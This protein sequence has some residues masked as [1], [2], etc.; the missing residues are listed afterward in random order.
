M[1]YRDSKFTPIVVWAAFLALGFV[2]SFASP[3]NSP[4][5]PETVA[6]RETVTASGVL[7]QD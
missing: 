1:T 6:A 4:R 2:T 5:K 3:P 7:A